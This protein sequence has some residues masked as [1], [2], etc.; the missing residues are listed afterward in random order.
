MA[1]SPFML[2]SVHTTPSTPVVPP[3]PPRHCV[4]SS[5]PQAHLISANNQSNP[6][7]VQ[8]CSS[9]LPNGNCFPK[10]NVL[11]PINTSPRL[12]NNSNNTSIN[13]MYFSND[14]LLSPQQ[15][16]TTSNRPR[17]ELRRS[18]EP[19]YHVMEY[20]TIDHP[21]LPH[22]AF[23]SPTMRNDFTFG[24]GYQQSQIDLPKKLRLTTPPPMN[25]SME[26]RRHTSTLSQILQNNDDDPFQRINVKRSRYNDRRED[27]DRDSDSSGSNGYLESSGIKQCLSPQQITPINTMS[28]SPKS[29]PVTTNDSSDDT[30]S[31]FGE[32]V[33]QQQIL[34][35]NKGLR[36]F[37]K[38]VCDKVE[39]KGVT[40]YNEVADELAE[41][42]AA[43][44]Q[45]HGGNKVVDQ[46]NIRRRV[47]DALNVLMAMDII[48]KDKKEI[49]WLGLPGQKID[50]KLA[51]SSGT[52]EVEIERQKSELRELERQNRCLCERVEKAKVAFQDKIARHLHIRNLMRRNKLRQNPYRI[53]NK[54]KSD[55]EVYLPF[56]LI[57][58]PRETSVNVQTAQDGVTSFLSFQPHQPT[59][60]DDS[61]IL[62]YLGMDKISPEDMQQW[63][64]PEHLKWIV[65][66]QGDDGDYRISCNQ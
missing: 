33:P 64:N 1:T 30:G 45:E 54:L 34:R 19:N 36:H 63:V 44:T 5:D 49:R 10:N 17:L 3:P 38:Q 8:F 61:D 22:S 27:E 37:S 39:F 23:N 9:S 48:A 62:Q 58:C 16:V 4:Y 32:P 40:T 28:T 43:Q 7:Y 55:K 60:I 59:I 12:I 57:H 66:K 2:T 52:T 13:G 42:F 53:S 15:L 50:N 20:G 56:K 46:K 51:S 29:S 21:Q 24:R 11:P 6:L 65:T 25:Q 31:M 18:S 47:Y 41:G 26:T 35:Q 14:V